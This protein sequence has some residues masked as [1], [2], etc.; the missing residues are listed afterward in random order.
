MIGKQGVSR[1]RFARRAALS[2][3][4]LAASVLTGALLFGASAGTFTCGGAG[5][6]NGEDSF[7]NPA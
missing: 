7:A 5:S 1:R 2:V 6:V 4:A 3:G